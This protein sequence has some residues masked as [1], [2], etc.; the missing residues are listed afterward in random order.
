MNG[1]SHAA[2]NQDLGGQ[3]IVTLESDLGSP[4]NIS[5]LENADSHRMVTE[6]AQMITE[7]SQGNHMTS[8]SDDPVNLTMESD[9]AIE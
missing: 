3:G 8:Q 1:R 9:G 4:L 2:V 7:S 5:G 6:A